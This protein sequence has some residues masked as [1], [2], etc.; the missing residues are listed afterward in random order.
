MTV[1]V[2][3]AS[4]P[5]VPDLQ[6]LNR[7]VSQS[8]QQQTF[9]Q[10]VP[11]VLGHQDEKL[12]EYRVGPEDILHVQ[13]W[14]HPDLDRTVVVSREGVF[15]FPLI[16]EI[17]AQ[18]LTVAQLERKMAA[19]LGKGYIVNPQLSITVKEYKS[20]KVF[21]LGEV[22]NPGKYPLSGQ[23][24]LLEVLAQAGGPTPEAG[25]EIVVVRP[26]NDRHRNTPAS[27]EQSNGGEVITVDLQR[28]ADGDVRQNVVLRNGDSIYV[29]KARY[30]YVF[31][32]VKKPGRYV[33]TKDTTVLKAI[34]TAGGLTDVAAV[35]RT[36]IV[37]ERS[38]IR[39]K[40][41][42]TMTDSIFP[43]DIIMVPESFF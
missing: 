13:V 9:R 28:L 15:S 33:L 8:S 25:T 34:T 35:R 26:R 14:D 4:Y 10:N 7:P 41:K 40:V 29:T 1:L 43:E 31:G 17:S 37:R 20:Q 22:L 32:Q 27:L 42:A 18:G 30:Y 38:G 3:C 16:G 23:T 12:R 21:L 36:K 5:T 2:G 39:I 19:R 11:V 24:T 6:E